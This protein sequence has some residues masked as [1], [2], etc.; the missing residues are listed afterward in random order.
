[1]EKNW[2]HQPYI[3]I[4]K[5]PGKR[6]RVSLLPTLGFRGG[7]HLAWVL[8]GR[9]HLPH[10][11]SLPEEMDHSCVLPAH[12]APGLQ[13]VDTVPSICDSTMP[14]LSRNCHHYVQGK[15]HIYLNLILLK[16]LCAGYFPAPISP[17]KLPM[18]NLT[19]LGERCSFQENSSTALNQR[20]RCTAGNRDL[21]VGSPRLCVT[22]VGDWWPA[23]LSCSARTSS[24]SPELV[25]LPSRPC[26]SLLKNGRRVEATSLGVVSS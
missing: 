21:Q 5:N 14:S 24:V 11:K 25:I 26:F 3:F 17:P 13:W 20:E 19:S 10:R 15:Q 16:N 7:I 22:G 12:T 18:P 4:L 23:F 1:M 8:P 9:P 2:S 6:M